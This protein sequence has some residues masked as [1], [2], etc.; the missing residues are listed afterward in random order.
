MLIILMQVGQLDGDWASTDDSNWH[1]THWTFYCRPHA[2]SDILADT[3]W[4]ATFPEQPCK[5]ASERLDQSGFWWSKRWQW[6]QLDHMQIICTL[7][8]TDSHASTPHHSIF[9]KPEPTVSKHCRQ[10]LFKELSLKWWTRAWWIQI[11]FLIWVNGLI[12]CSILLKYASLLQK[13]LTMYV[14]AWMH[15]QAWKHTLSRGLCLFQT[16]LWHSSVLWQC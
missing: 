12:S 2:Y 7:L 13:K 10:R 9:Y 4:T 3:C 8:Q 11:W 5:P 6:H 16:G 14:Q 1:S 15:H